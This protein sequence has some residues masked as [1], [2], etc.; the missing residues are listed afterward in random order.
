M[1]CGLQAEQHNELVAVVSK[2][3]K[4][5]AAAEK[6]AAAAAA[7]ESTANDAPSVP[8]STNIAGNAAMALQQV[9]CLKSHSC[10]A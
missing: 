1:R 5:E 10:L 6:E 4:Q 2:L 7:R 3:A 9:M 8:A